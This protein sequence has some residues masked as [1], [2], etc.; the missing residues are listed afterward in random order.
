MNTRATVLT[1]CTTL[2][3]LVPATQAA[4]GSGPACTLHANHATTR[5]NALLARP[6]SRALQYLPLDGAATANPPAQ[7]TCSTIRNTPLI[8]PNHYQVARNAR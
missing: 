6:G 2:A 7:K 5:H 4:A 8:P 1:L 3:L